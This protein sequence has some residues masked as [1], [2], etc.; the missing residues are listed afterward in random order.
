[1]ATGIIKI[2]RCLLPS[3]VNYL[4]C[5]RPLAE[6]NTNTTGD[7]KMNTGTEIII[8]TA[9]ENDASATPEDKARI[10]AAFDPKP[11]RRKVIPLT[12]KEAAEFFDIH[13]VTLRRWEKEGRIKAIRL[14]PRK[15]RWDRNVLED[16]IANGMQE[17]A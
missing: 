16:L 9:I 13:V 11:T 1:M 7:R 15:I 10:I 4:S 2:T 14:S 5:E 12:T 6:N 3:P 17:V 8:K